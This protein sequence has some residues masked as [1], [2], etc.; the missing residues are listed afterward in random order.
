MITNNNEQEL[1]VLFKLLDDHHILP[2]QQL[3][4]L[5]NR[6]LGK[7]LIAQNLYNT[8]PEIKVNWFE[9]II[10]VKKIILYCVDNKIKILTRYNQSI[11]NLSNKLTKFGDAPF[12]IY[13]L[14]NCDLLANKNLTGVFYDDQFLFNNRDLY[15]QLIQNYDSTA[16]F[17]IPKTLASS[18]FTFALQSINRS[19]IFIT[20]AYLSDKTPIKKDYLVLSNN[21]RYD[22]KVLQVKG[23]TRDIMSTL[24]DSA[25]ILNGK[26]NHDL[27][28]NLKN[29]GVTLIAYDSKLLPPSSTNIYQDNALADQIITL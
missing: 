13:A 28:T 1:C 18:V 22:D 3:S 24:I 6:Y 15:G 4:E 12:A 27:L 23:Q 11:A 17:I 2:R 10:T 16:T 9:Y 19:H 7:E 14:G 8:Y 26:Y 5:I 21:C 25:L 20:D 29:N